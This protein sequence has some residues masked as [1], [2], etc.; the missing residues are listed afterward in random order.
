MGMAVC[1]EEM[2]R[3]IFGAGRGQTRPHPMT[4]NMKWCVE[5]AATPEAEG[6]LARPLS[7]QGAVRSSFAMTGRIRAADRTPA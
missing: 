6:A 7:C 2:N 5:R 3:S 4:A 1:Y